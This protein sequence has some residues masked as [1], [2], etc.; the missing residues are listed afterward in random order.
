MIMSE[1]FD[2]QDELEFFDLDCVFDSKLYIDPDLVINSNILEFRNSQNEIDEFLSLGFSLINDEKEVTAQKL[3]CISE[4]NETNLGQRE[5]SLYGK[6]SGQSKANYL[7]LGVKNILK[8]V[9]KLDSL[10]DLNILCPR[11]G[12]D[13]ISDFT[14]AILKKKF[15]AYTQRMAKKYSMPM[16]EYLVKNYEFS[17]FENKW[18]D[19]NIEL[20]FNYELNRGIILVPKQFLVSEINM[21]MSKFIQFLLED[22]TLE[23]EHGDLKKKDISYIIT[24]ALNNPKKLKEFHERVKSTHTSYNFKKDPCNLVKYYELGQFLAFEAIAENKDITCY[25][26]N[27]LYQIFEDILRKKEILTKNLKFYARTFYTFLSFLIPHRLK[28]LY[29]DHKDRKYKIIFD[30]QVE[31]FDLVTKRKE[32]KFMKQEI[33][34]NI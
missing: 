33:S 5:C 19:R 26:Y 23:N 3:F 4:T 18:L 24:L 17:T 21:S 10:S 25:N 8:K 14:M 22:K 30:N 16:K 1:I 28:H 13:R 2:L 7:I 32:T 29:L 20:P 11:M 12:N 31:V 15:V 27:E 9:T 6:A 34:I